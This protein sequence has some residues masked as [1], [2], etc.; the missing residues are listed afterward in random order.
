MSQEND[1]INTIEN[2]IAL[3]H[4][5]SEASEKDVAETIDDPSTLQL[6][7]LANKEKMKDDYLVKEKEKEEESVREEESDVVRGEKKSSE[8]SY[9]SDRLHKRNKRIKKE[10]KD[11]ETREKKNNLLF[12]LS[13]ISKIY[14]ITYSNSYNIV[15]YTLDELEFEHL[16][17]S[18][19][20][21]IS[22]GV[23]FAKNT[24]LFGIQSLEFLNS[25]YD[26]LGI[27][28]T[29]YNEAMSYS[30]QEPAYDE[31]LADVYKKYFVSVEMD[32]LV[33]LGLMM[34]HNTVMFVASKKIAESYGKSN[35]SGPS[36]GRGDDDTDDDIL[37]SAIDG[38]SQKLELEAIISKMGKAPAKRGRKKGIT[39]KKKSEIQT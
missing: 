33:K 4:P 3:S 1:D 22:N 14:K 9:H 25:Y 32:P 13:Q 24:L 17:A 2:T 23:A 26:P 27:D 10:N 35:F 21:E 37:E 30:M 19:E 29:G 18:K 38:P 15:D 7:M 16:K 20:L 36:R 12:K 39:N 6:N 34:S 5:A 11:P 8:N 31:V 28:L